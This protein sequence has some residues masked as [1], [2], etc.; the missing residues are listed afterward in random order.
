[1]SL[2]HSLVVL[3][4]ERVVEYVDGACTHV[5]QPGRHRS[6]RHAGTAASR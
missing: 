2:F 5:L 4:G 3:M 1:M 6:R